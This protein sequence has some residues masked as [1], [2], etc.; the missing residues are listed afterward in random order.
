MFACTFAALPTV[1]VPGSPSSGSY[2]NTGGEYTLL[3]WLSTSVPPNPT[4]RSSCRFVANRSHVR[5]AVE[6]L[7]HTPSSFLIRSIVCSGLEL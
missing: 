1:D 6:M 3:V 4:K 7:R 5:R 2:C